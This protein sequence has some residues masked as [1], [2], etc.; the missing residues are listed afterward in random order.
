MSEDRKKVVGQ[1][2]SIPPLQVKVES[3]DW[4]RYRHLLRKGDIEVTVHPVFSAPDGTVDFDEVEIRPSDP[5]LDL[6]VE[7]EEKL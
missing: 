6:V 2:F 4:V 5:A 3:D 7:E 1:V